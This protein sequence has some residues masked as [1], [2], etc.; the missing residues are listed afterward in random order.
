MLINLISVNGGN[1]LIALRAALNKEKR[2][3]SADVMT[4]TMNAMQCKPTN[5]ANAMSNAMQCNARN[6]PVAVP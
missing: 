6:G 5:N 4:R 2:A 1:A 3:M